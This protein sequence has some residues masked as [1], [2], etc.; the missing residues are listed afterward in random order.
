MGNTVGN[1]IDSL[2]PT[3]KFGKTNLLILGCVYI[4]RIKNSSKIT[5]SQRVGQ[6]LYKAH[7][8]TA[9]L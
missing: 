8:H 3:T 5:R 4:A 1:S 9:N 6:K 2:L 7:E